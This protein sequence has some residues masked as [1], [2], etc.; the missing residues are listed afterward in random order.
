MEE[1][2]VCE[3]LGNRRRE[4]EALHS[5]KVLFDGQKM[6]NLLLIANDEKKHYAAIKNL[7]RLLASSNSDGKRR[8][9]FCLNCL[10]GFHSQ[11]SR[12]K[13]FEYCVDNVAVMI[14]MSEEH[15]FVRFHRQ[16]QFKVPFII[17]A[18]FKQSSQE[19]TEPDPEAPYM[20]RINCHVP[21][22]FCPYSTC[23][24][25]EVKDPLRLYRGKDCVDVFCN[26]IKEEAKRLYH[27]FPERP[28]KHLTQ[29]QWRE[30]NRATK[31]Y[32]C[33]NDFG[34]DDIKMRDH[35]HYMGLY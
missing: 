11:A 10:Q 28:M 18:D 19:E 1:Q 26:H 30:F 23:A 5:Q 20:K 14:N 15:S 3:R 35:C 12:D 13:H 7:S 25:R 27:M 22:G 33:L 31:C 16:Y 2:Y 6:A 24:Y 17:Y 4:R 8:E 32:I 9:Y 21:S 34:E 29:E